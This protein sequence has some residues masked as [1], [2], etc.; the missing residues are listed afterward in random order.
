MDD[1]D[2]SLGAS[3][4]EV[5]SLCEQKALIPINCIFEE[6]KIIQKVGEGVFG[7]VFLGQFNG[8]RRVYKVVPIEGTER[9]N[10]EKQKTFCEIF[11]EIA[12][13]K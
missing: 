8:Q 4:K 12:I 13:S 1:F 11:P 5:L 6:L 9:V 7:E 3:K 2:I 10:G